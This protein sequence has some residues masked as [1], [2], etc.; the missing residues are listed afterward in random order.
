MEVFFVISVII[1]AILFVTVSIVILMYCFGEYD[2][3][4]KE[5]ID[6]TLEKIV[7]FFNRRNL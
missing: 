6:P 1:G 7:T 2:S 5:K 3:F 4:I